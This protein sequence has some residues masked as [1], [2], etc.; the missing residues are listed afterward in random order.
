MFFLRLQKQKRLSPQRTQRAQRK[1]KTQ[2]ALSPATCYLHPV[3][4]NL[5]PLSSPINRS[6]PS[7]PSSANRHSSVACATSCVNIARRGDSNDVASENT[8][9]PRGKGRN[10]RSA[11]SA[12]RNATAASRARTASSKD[13]SGGD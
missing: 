12:W 5:F 7:S 9:T 13:R 11:S 4:C 6:L 1:P 10:A 2:E 8:A 3:T